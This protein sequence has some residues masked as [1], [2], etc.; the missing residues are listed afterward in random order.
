MR[1]W[2]AQMAEIVPT[3]VG[4]NRDCFG[5]IYDYA[6]RPHARGGEPKPGLTFPK[7][8]ASSPRAW[9]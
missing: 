9:G 7:K 2:R 5:R 1:D 6:N 3:R 8:A 4:V